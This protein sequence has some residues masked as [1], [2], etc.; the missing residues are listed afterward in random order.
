[1]LA[2]QTSAPRIGGSLNWSAEKLDE[3]GARKQ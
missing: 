3:N 1:M 2:F